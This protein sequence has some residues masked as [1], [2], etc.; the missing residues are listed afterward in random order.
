MK[1]SAYNKTTG[2]LTKQIANTFI[3]S[4]LSLTTA[5]SCT[6]G[7]LA[8]ALCAEA[9][10]AKF[11]DIGIITFREGANKRGNSSRLTQSF[12]FFMF[13]PIFSPVNALNQPI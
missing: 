7:L 8:A 10:T 2:E 5:E 9:D 4:R 11:Y 13:E 12:H 3:D 1:K 6:G